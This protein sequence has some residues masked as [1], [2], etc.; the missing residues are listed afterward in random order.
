MKKVITIV[1]ARPQFVKAAV[2]SRA[3]KKKGTLQEVIV[4]TGQHY[5]PNMSQVFFDELHIPAPGYDL[6]VGSG[7]HGVQ[8]A[9][10]LQKIEE[11]L[12]KE[13]PA[14]VLLYGDTNSTVAGS[15]A[16]VKLHIPI[17]H[18]EAGLRGFDKKVPE[19][20][21]RIVTDHLSTVLFCPTDTAVEN[22]KNEGITK[23]VFNT[24]DVMYDST[25]YMLEHAEKKNGL[26]KELGLTTKKYCLATIHRAENTDSKDNLTA[27]IN[28]LKGSGKKIVL[29]LHPRTKK[30]LEMYS[31]SLPGTIVTLPPLGYT[32]MLILEK[33]AEYIVTDSGGVQKE[34]YFV[35][36]PC[37]TLRDHTEWVETVQSGANQTIGPNEKKLLSALSKPAPVLH[38]LPDHYGDGHAGEKIVDLLNKEI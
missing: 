32:D 21:N 16:A 6:E 29:P 9:L 1:G 38:D 23:K 19:E 37:V 24:G 31:I 12:L 2:I 5:D 18:V 15:L 8:T 17:A 7:S 28:A 4:H 27:I 11:V 36:T 3:I 22:L 13:K 30:Y 14:L 20:V 34:A 25:L 33:N 35:R 10:M 26:L